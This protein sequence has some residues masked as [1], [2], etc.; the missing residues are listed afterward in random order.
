ME[1]A[2]NQVMKNKWISVLSDEPVCHQPLE[3][4]FKDGKEDTGFKSFW[5]GFRKLN[6]DYT[7]TEFEDVTHWRYAQ[8]ECE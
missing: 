1:I 5:G 8:P 6:E 7:M 3:L 4:K 2:F